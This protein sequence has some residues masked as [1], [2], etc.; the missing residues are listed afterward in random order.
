MVEVQYAI[1]EPGF[2]KRKLFDHFT[3]VDTALW[4]LSDL[5]E[6]LGMQFEGDVD[7]NWQ[8]DLVGKQLVVI[9]EHEKRTKGPRTGQLCEKII[10]Y[11]SIED[12]GIDS[13]LG[14]PGGLE[15]EN[16]VPF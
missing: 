12:Q 15:Q 6:V 2:E 8:D 10:G 14:S 5:L 3:L 1:E 16:E 9:V 7:M 4:K 11:R 13:D